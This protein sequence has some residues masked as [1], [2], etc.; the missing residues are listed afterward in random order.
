MSFY[1]VDAGYPVWDLDLWSCPNKEDEQHY[2]LN[3]QTGEIID[4]PK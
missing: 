4:L 1:N 3:A 2:Y